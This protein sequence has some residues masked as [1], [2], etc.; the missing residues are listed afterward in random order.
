MKKT[1]MELILMFKTSPDDAM[2]ALIQQYTGLVWSICSK[3]LNH[4]EDMKE[5]V[6]ETFS[7]FYRRYESFDMQKGTIASYLGAIARNRAITKY[8]KNSQN[9]QNVT[10]FEEFTAD[11][12]NALEQA[13]WKLVLEQALKILSADEQ[14]II[15]L[16]YYEE[17]TVQEI[18]DALGLPY[19][20]VK[21]RHQRTLG[22][23]KKAL[24]GL[25]IF[26]LISVLAAC[27][28]MVLRYFGVV[29][30][31][32]INVS[33][34]V[35]VY[36][37]EEAV[38]G[39]GYESDLI[40]TQSPDKQ[41]SYILD[42]A[43]LL[44]GMLQI[45]L[46]VTR[47]YQTGMMPNGDSRLSI[48]GVSYQPD[49]KT[50]APVES[51]TE[52]LSLEYSGIPVP[53]L[54]TKRLDVSFSYGGVP[55]DFTLVSVSE[56]AIE[57]FSTA[58]VD[59]RGLLAIPK[60]IAGNLI[61]EIHPLNQEP[62][63]ILPSLVRCIY[64][65]LDSDVR[66]VTLTDPSGN[67]LEG[68]CIGYSPM[69][70]APYYD[71]S[72]GPA[73]PGEYTLH[74]PY[75]YETLELPMDLSIELDV[76]NGIDTETVYEIPGGSLQTVSCEKIAPEEIPSHEALEI[77]PQPDMDYWVVTLEYQGDH[78]NLRLLDFNLNAFMETGES[79]EAVQ[80]GTGI[81]VAPEPNQVSYLL[82]VPKS[83]SEIS[84]F[85][86]RPSQSMMGPLLYRR[87]EQEFELSFVVE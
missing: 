46:H 45:K 56:N 20:T 18:A 82:S 72:F 49:R 3:H 83:D 35:A 70:S 79:K 74:V 75:L 54:D 33:E 14:K 68:Q 36:V 30:G 11:P 77:I 40:G 47:E 87:W 1:D 73:V 5:C 51:L 84:R 44:N 2:E 31:Y 8:Q 34:N 24:L 85:V 80:V 7:E 32:G 64:E 15:Q 52:L 62:I 61:V 42:D 17:M 6:N 28:Y 37:L 29:P 19:E 55:L 66:P 25:L 63:T 78:E 12:S 43:F 71:W 9:S 4:I 67:R 23:L 48:D 69:S 50:Y 38:S 76:E 13:E 59:G 60:Q 53:E 57:E 65:E 10:C 26:V 27:A 16:K 22:K 41:V 21:K 86:L 81:V 58:I 39:V